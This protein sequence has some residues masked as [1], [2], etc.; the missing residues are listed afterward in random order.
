MGQKEGYDGYD[1][2]SSSQDLFGTSLDI[3]GPMDMNMEG[4][5][6]T[7]GVKFHLQTPMK[8]DVLHF[9]CPSCT[10]I[11]STVTTAICSRRKLTCTDCRERRSKKKSCSVTQA[12]LK[13]GL[14]P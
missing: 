12:R 6:P 10:E 3:A 11:L 5:P 7:P 2:P 4:P 13:P 8:V 1:V 14:T 9:V